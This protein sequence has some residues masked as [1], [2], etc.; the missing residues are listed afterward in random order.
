MSD[1]RT[2]DISLMSAKE[3]EITIQ[4]DNLI[5]KEWV[6]MLEPKKAMLKFRC[7]YTSDY[8]EKDITFIDG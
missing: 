5:Q 3:H 1:I 8:S 2:A 6:S 4:K 7:P